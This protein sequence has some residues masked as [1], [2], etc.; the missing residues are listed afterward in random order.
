M[1][2]MP[3]DSLPDCQG[4]LNRRNRLLYTYNSYG[5]VNNNINEKSILRIFDRSN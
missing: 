2:E 5:N 1:R 4:L 3:R